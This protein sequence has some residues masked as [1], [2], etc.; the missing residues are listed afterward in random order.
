MN[1]VSCA[2][3]QSTGTPGEVQG[4]T[5]GLPWVRTGCRAASTAAGFVAVWSTIRLLMTRGCESKTLPFFWAYDD[6]GTAGLPGPKKPAGAPSAAL[7]TGAA[8]RGNTWS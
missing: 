4:S 3:T 1:N 5:P 2:G 8:T 7:N 6:D